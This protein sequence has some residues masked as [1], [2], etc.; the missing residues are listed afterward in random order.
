M[1]QFVVKIQ[2]MRICIDR[3]TLVEVDCK[4]LDASFFGGDTE[5]VFAWKV[6]VT[7]AFNLLK[8]DETLTSVSLLACS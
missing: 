4:P 2:N 6:A 7:K 1:Y 5:E 8:E 3:E